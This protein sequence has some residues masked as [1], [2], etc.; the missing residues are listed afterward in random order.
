MHADQVVLR[1]HR[2]DLHAMRACRQWARDPWLLIP[3]LCLTTGL[4][5]WPVAGQFA[6]PTDVGGRV[7][8]AVFGER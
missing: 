3:A 6:Q 2:P 4:W 1:P 8:L 7:G 5:W